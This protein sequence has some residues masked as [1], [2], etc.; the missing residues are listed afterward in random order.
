MIALAYAGGTVGA[1]FAARLVRSVGQRPTAFAGI[2]FMALSLMA[3]AWTTATT[4]LSL[5]AVLLLI[6]GSAYGLLVVA[7]TDIVTGTLAQRDRGVAGSLSLL[8]RTLGVV[9]GATLLSA[10]QAHGAGGLGGAEGF[11]AG[12]R[13]AFM[14]AGGGLLAALLLSCVWPRAW[15]GR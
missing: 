2:L 6:H 13:F 3:L 10:L 12:Y 9:S 1:P 11:L 4:P 7:Y 8:T 14:V 15:F 5:L